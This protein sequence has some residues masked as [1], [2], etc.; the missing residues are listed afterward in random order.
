VNTREELLTAAKEAAAVL[1]KSTISVAEFCR[2]TGVSSNQIYKH[3]DGWRDLCAQ[4]GLKP[5]L[6]NVRLADED[7]FSAMRDTFLELGGI[8]TRGKFDKHFRYSV[9]V[10]KK[11]GLNWSSALAEFHKW[12]LDNDPAFP[13]LDKLPVD[14]LSGAAKTLFEPQQVAGETHVWGPKGGRQFGELI[15]FRGLLHAPVEEQGVVFLFGM[16]A[17]DLGYIVETVTTGFPDC[18]AKRRVREG[19]WEKVR[20]EFEYQSRTFSTHGHNPHGCDVIVCW[21]DNWP[22]C[23]V[24][25]LELKTAISRLDRE[26]C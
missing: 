4:A 21:E 22:E 9:D 5:N 11:R 16:I 8:V 25:V 7:I 15:N 20:I 24:E 18:E 26:K 13:Y 17:H 1:G 14:T 6:Q 3:F 19:R 10:F 23:P 2:H 12:A